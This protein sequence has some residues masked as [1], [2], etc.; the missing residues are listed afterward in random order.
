VEPVRLAI[1]HLSETYSKVHTGEHLCYTQPIQIGLT[2]GDV[3]L[4]LLFK[5]TL[6]YYILASCRIDTP[7]I[8]LLLS[9]MEHKLLF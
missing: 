9:L 8:H 5:F 4:P 7:L 6:E 1:N 3:T 2:K